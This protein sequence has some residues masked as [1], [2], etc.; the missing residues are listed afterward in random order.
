MRRFVLFWTVL[1][2]LVS[3]SVL[4]AWT[5]PAVL[6]ARTQKAIDKAR[7]YLNQGQLSSA[8]D[9]Y[10]KANKISKG[11]CAVCLANIASLYLQTGDNKRAAQ[12]AAKLDLIATAPHDK[13][14]AAL[15]EGSAL[16]RLA[17][18][19]KKQPQFEQ[20]HEQFQRVILLQPEASQAYFLD[21]LAL[22]NLRNDAAAREAFQKYVASPGADALMRARASRYIVD[23]RLT[24]Q[25]LAPPFSIQTL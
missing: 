11:Q 20:A 6:D 7:Q 17:I 9:S 25:K 22:G 4:S 5:M 24:Q 16:L 3:S 14:Q 23:P 12:S 2:C 21:G 13:A 8:I 18:A 19:G 15:L 1:F 10:N